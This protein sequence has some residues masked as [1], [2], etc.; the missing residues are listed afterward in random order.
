MFYSLPITKRFLGFEHLFPVF[1]FGLSSSAALFAQEK[2]GES[3]YLQGIS[4]DGVHPCLM[5]NWATLQISVT[6]QSGVWRDGRVVVFYS[7]QQ[8][9]QYARDIN[10]PGKSTL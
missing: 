5:D 2:Q 9:V 7:G 3:F 10:L 1:I 6:N 8:D 4:Q